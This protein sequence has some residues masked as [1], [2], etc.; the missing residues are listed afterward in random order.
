MLLV[1][2]ALGTCTLGVELPA[3]PGA[4]GLG[5]LVQEM[6]DIRTPFD[7]DGNGGLRAG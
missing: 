7:C 6:G 2:G 1:L 4:R 5:W 3:R